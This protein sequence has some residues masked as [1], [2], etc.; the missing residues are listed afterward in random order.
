MSTITDDLAVKTLV[1]RTVSDAL[2]MP[3]REALVLLRGLIALGG[4]HE[5]IDPVRSAYVSL[6]TC[7]QQLELIVT[8]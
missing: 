5:A 8:Q 2:N 6:N 4:E 3:C 1:Q 7:E